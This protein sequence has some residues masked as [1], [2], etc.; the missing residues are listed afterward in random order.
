MYKTTESYEAALFKAFAY[1]FLG[2]KKIDRPNGKTAIEFEFDVPSLSTVQNIIKDYFNHIL[3]VD[4]YEF[5]EALKF[6]KKEIYTKLKTKE[7]E[8]SIKSAE[9]KDVLV[10]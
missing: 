4:A 10:L 3:E 7:S 6:T 9:S 5:Y 2:S 8:V 1:P